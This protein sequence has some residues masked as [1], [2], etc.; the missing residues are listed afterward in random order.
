MGKFPKRYCPSPP[1]CCCCCCTEEDARKKEDEEEEEDDPPKPKDPDPDPKPPVLAKTLKQVF[2]TKHIKDLEN[3]WEESRNLLDKELSKRKD[4]E[5][6]LLKRNDPNNIG[7]YEDLHS[8]CCD[9]IYVRFWWVEFGGQDPTPVDGS[10]VNTSVR[11]PWMRRLAGKSAVNSKTN[12][13]NEQLALKLCCIYAEWLSFRSCTICREEETEWNGSSGEKNPLLE[14]ANSETWPTALDFAMVNEQANLMKWAHESCKE[15][16]SED[17]RK[18]ESEAP[19]KMKEYQSKDVQLVQAKQEL[20]RMA[21]NDQAAMKWAVDKLKPK[22][23]ENLDI[24]KE[25]EGRATKTTV[26]QASS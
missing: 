8:G 2:A 24:W 17:T 14:L 21:A 13:E 11:V 7:Y 26:P 5:Q 15:C 16:F 22:N 12:S 1:C 3:T 6:E 10:N 18:I 25:L 23:P 4:L 20:A 19:Q 9:C